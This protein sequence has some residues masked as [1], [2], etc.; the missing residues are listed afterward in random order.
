MG[1]VDGHQHRLSSFQKLREAGNTQALGCDVE[2]VQLAGKIAGAHPTG[3]DAWAA[4]VNALGPEPVF[5]ELLYLIFHERDEWRDHQRGAAEGK[6]WELVAK[7]LA[8]PGGHDH[9][10]VA[11]REDGA[12]RRFLIGPELGESK[13][14][15]EK[16]GQIRGAQIQLPGLR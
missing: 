2:K 1:L 12:T 14:R 5:T 8:R 3:L 10:G 16:S 13:S 6:P 15:A 9:Q 11:S 7:G 4:R